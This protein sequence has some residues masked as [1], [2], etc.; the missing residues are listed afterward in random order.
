MEFLKKESLFLFFLIMISGLIPLISHGADLPNYEDEKKQSLN[1]NLVPMV[2]E[3]QKLAG[4]ATAG[5]GEPEDKEIKE[6]LKADRIM[7]QIQL[8][9]DTSSPIVFPTS[10]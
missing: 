4:E 8:E 7:Q 1:I 6:R 10:K 5:T 9:G 3:D 2:Y